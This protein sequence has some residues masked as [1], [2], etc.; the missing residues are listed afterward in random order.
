M[1]RRAV[2]GSR[3][4]V[5][6]AAVL[7]AQV[8]SSGIG[9]RGAERGI[10]HPFDGWV[11][12]GA[13]D[14]LLTP[15]VRWDAQWYLRIAEHGYQTHVESLRAGRAFFP[16]Y[17]LVVKGLGG[18]AGTGAALLAA[19]AISLAAFAVALRL[20][21]RLA[22]LDLGPR[23]ADATVLLLAF[24]PAAYF[25]SAPYTESLF[26]LLTVGAFLAARQ[27]SWAIAG[28]A[29]GL[30]S[31]T[32]PTGLLLVVPLALL[33]LYGPRGDRDARGDA[34]SAGGGR[35]R[36]LLPRHRPRPDLLWLALAPAGVIAYSIY[37]RHAAGDALAWQH[38]QPLFGRTDAE[39]PTEA[40]RQA[41]AAAVDAVQGDG[42]DAYRGPILVESAYLLL[43]LAAVVGV[44]R[45]LPF[46]YG[47]YLVGALLLALYSPAHAD[48]LRSLPRLLLPVFPLAMWL[49]SCTERRGVA[50]YAVAVSAIA[51]V[52]LTAAFASW[53][54]YV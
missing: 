6:A 36:A 29:A 15:L 35:W 51:L 40:L 46:A 9:A 54:P 53:R 25:F 42:V 26:L 52:L 38:V 1:V 30:A 16:L 8:L 19:T 4:L 23:G 49:A 47:V 7:G 31:A 50:R 13:L 3:L 22:T 45:R 17:P 37:L 43:A 27:G 12:G 2:V 33:Y 18:F 34:G 32:R 39:W 44:F 10:V 5:L 20:L 24:A 48:P 21:H 41:V 11:L 28:A 14:R